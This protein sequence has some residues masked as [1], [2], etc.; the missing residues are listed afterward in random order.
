MS[1]VI[2]QEDDRS[3]T[4]MEYQPK[5]LHMATSR[6]AENF[7]SVQP[8]AP[9]SSFRLSD[10]IAQ[11]TGIQDLERASVERRIEEKALERLQEIQER[12]YQEAYSLGMDEGVQKGFQEAQA[13]VTEKL[14]TLNTLT[15]NLMRIKTDVLVRNEAQML[16]LIFVFASNIARFEIAK[17]EQRVLPVLREAIESV[18]KDE[19]ML[20]KVSPHDMNQ[21]EDLKKISGQEFAHL[22]AAKFEA[23]ESITP[24]GCLIET[25]YGQ[26]DATVEERISKLASV[27]NESKPQTKK[28]QFE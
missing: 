26:I 5:K 28:D 14:S 10:L 17:N 16:D 2:F 1:T 21:V 22:I 3:Q 7:V 19:A 18:Q 23:N 4:V 8:E 15:E 6:A 27:L 11:Q 9:P 24:G 13:A 20:I 12:A 25:N